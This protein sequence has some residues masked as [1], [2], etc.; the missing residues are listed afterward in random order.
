M[1]KWL[2]MTFNSM[3]IYLPEVILLQYILSI[4][5]LAVL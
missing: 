4:N 2:L 1:S 5:V 3:T